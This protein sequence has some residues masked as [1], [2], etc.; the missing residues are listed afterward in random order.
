MGER[1]AGDPLLGLARGLTFR[2]KIQPPS[3]RIIGDVHEEMGQ[4]PFQPAPWAR[5][6]LVQFGSDPFAV[7]ELAFEIAAHHRGEALVLDPQH[8]L[9]IDIKAAIVEVR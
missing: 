6:A 2:S 5:P 3:N 8:D 1:P 7:R 9:Q 4:R